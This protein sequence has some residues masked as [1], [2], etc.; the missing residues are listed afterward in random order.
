VGAD[1]ATFIVT[2]NTVNSTA[3]GI[4]LYDLNGRKVKATA[5]TTLGISDLSA[6]IYVA[7]SG[8]AVKKIVVK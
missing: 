2:A 6:G 7:K 8:N 3:A 1:N 5:S 4:E